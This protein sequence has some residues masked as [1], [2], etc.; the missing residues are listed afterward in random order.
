LLRFILNVH[1][2]KK[3]PFKIEPDISTLASDIV[4]VAC[5]HEPR[6]RSVLAASDNNIRPPVNTATLINNSKSPSLT[7]TYMSSTV[8]EH[9]PL[10]DTLLYGTLSFTG[11]SRF[12]ESLSVSFEGSRIIETQG[13][14]GRPL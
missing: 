7:G 5:W 13:D 12:T 6:L 3:N 1:K 9:S 14:V 11:R 2:H 4:G 8:T 10:R